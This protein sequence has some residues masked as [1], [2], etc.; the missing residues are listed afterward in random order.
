MSTISF[1]VRFH[2]TTTSGF[3]TGQLLSDNDYRTIGP[4]KGCDEIRQGRTKKY[5]AIAGQVVTAYGRTYGEHVYEILEAPQG[6]DIAGKNAVDNSDAY[7]RSGQEG[8]IIFADNYDE[9]P[10]EN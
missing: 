3:N 5:V 8:K 7:P 2:K 10:E 4:F 1:R 9:L 6:F